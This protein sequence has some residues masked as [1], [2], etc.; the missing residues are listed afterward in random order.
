MALSLVALRLGLAVPGQ[1][2]VVA[3]LAIWG[4]VLWVLAGLAFGALLGRLFTIRQGKRLFGLVGSG[5][6]LAGI[7][8]GLLVPLA[9][10]LVGTA[11]LLLWRRAASASPCWCSGPCS[12]RRPRPRLVRRRSRPRWPRAS[13]C[14]AAMWA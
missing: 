5:E 8:G 1:P 2:V 13:S 6:V 7:L 4:E 10:S 12:V 11:N 14:V 3:A 9:V